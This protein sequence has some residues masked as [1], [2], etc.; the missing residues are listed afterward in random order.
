MACVLLLQQQFLVSLLPP[1]HPPET[2]LTVPD[3][4]S[5]TEE[6]GASDAQR[7]EVTGPRARNLADVPHVVREL[8]RRFAETAAVRDTLGGTPK[9]QRDEIRRSGLLALTVPQELGGLG[10]DWPLTLQVVRQFARV[11]SSVAHLFAFHH[12]MLAT[13]S[14][15]GQPEQWQPW[16]RHTAQRDWFWGNALNPL[17]RR[18]LCRQLEG[19]VEFSGK[20]S[21]CSGALDSEMLVASAF[22]EDDGS[23]VVAAVPTSRSGISLLDDWN[24]IGQRQTDSGSV[25]F[26]RVRIHNADVLSDP[27]PLST[28][29]SC[30]RP[31]VAQLILVNIYIGIAEGAFED[32]RQYTL[33]EARPRIATGESVA[34]DDPQVQASFGDFVTSLE[35]MRVLGD[36][37][38]RRLG[39]ALA[40]GDS[41]SE[42]ERGDVAMATAAA[43]VA[44]TRGGLDICNRLFEVI[45]ARSTHAELGLDRHWRNLRTHT[46]HDPLQRKL[47]EL[48][49]WALTGRFP[50]PSFYS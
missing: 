8:A 42:A 18:T 15:F 5:I 46:L 12:L 26:E 34:A 3:L 4:L 23:L 48:G 37:A 24:S 2:P 49:D 38:E 6:A 35:V 47:Q 41:L 10:G 44:A 28:P 11:D 36:R 50:A 43:K 45:G 21:F 17:D 25:N 40:R 16:F 29:R 32:A 1:S 30:L 33:K 7:G 9:R 27:G 19:H 13:A 20:K 31:L 14:L 39:A 22:R